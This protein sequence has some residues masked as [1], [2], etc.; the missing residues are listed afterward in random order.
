MKVPEREQEL[1]APPDVTV[2]LSQEGSAIRLAIKRP[3]YVVALRSRERVSVAQDW[4]S[5][6]VEGFDGRGLEMQWETTEPRSLETVRGGLRIAGAP[7]VR[8]SIGLRCRNRWWLPRAKNRLHT[9]SRARE[10][11]RLHRALQGRQVG[12]QALGVQCDRRNP[13]LQ[14]VDVVW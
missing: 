12:S 14:C 4:V 9:L 10:R 5:A 11:R 6:L 7:R 3:G 1:P 13:A 8:P 2:V